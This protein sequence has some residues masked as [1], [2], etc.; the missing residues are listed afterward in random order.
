MLDIDP[1]RG[2][3]LLWRYTDR[4]R[5]LL[6]LLY[7]GLGLVVYAPLLW[8]WAVAD[9]GVF[10]VRYNIR[11]GRSADRTVFV[12][13]DGVEHQMAGWDPGEDLRPGDVLVKCP[14]EFHFRRLPPNTRRS[15]SPHWFEFGFEGLRWFGLWAGIGMC[16]WWLVTQDFSARLV[17]KDGS[18]QMTLEA[19]CY[20]FSHRAVR[21]IR[22]GDVRAMRIDETT[23]RNGASHTLMLL[24]RGYDELEAGVFP[25][26]AA[27][28]RFRQALEGWIEAER[29]IEPEVAPG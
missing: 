13:Q 1:T 27:A 19:A 2:S 26:A 20:P 18:G 29:K 21:I 11:S 10:T 28:A 6:A 4:K 5:R 14:G 24:L 12:N 8:D 15:E 23:T 3:R 17:L 25:T 9:T 7:V 22:A 16:A